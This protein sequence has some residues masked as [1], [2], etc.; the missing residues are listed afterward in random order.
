[1]AMPLEDVVHI[2][3]VSRT[4]LVATILEVVAGRLDRLGFGRMSL[5]MAIVKYT[6]DTGGL[7]G[8]DHEAPE[9]NLGCADE[10][11]T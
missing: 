8:L 6:P 4:T 9:P 3:D 7:A 10:V 2:E 11:L 1:M 5:K